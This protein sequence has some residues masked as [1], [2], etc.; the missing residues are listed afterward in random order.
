MAAWTKS[1]LVA[2]VTG[3]VLIA[4]GGSVLGLAVADQ[5]HA[6]QPGP[7][8]AGSTAPVVAPAPQ[9]WPDP[10]SAMVQGPTMARS[11]PISISIPAIGVD[12]RLLYVGLNPDG[13]IQVPPLND[14]RLANEAAWYKYSPTPGQL[15]PSIVEGHVDSLKAGQ[16]VF[17][18][19]GD[20]KPGELVY[21]TLAD[22]QVAVFKITGVRLYPKNRFPTSAVYGNTDYA[23]LRLITCGGSFD[24][25]SRHYSS[26]VVA[27]ASLVSSRQAQARRGSP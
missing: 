18:R 22:R 21:I 2:I 6:A 25:R 9:K 12:S 4:A 15:G 27:F 14:P 13:T 1:R 24:A 10:G 20:L 23:A 5:Q 3:L 7:A 17:F 8:Q 11:L 16:A 19:L 26:N